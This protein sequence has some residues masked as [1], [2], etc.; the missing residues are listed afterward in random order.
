LDSDLVHDN[1]YYSDDNQ[2][3]MER[4]AKINKSKQVPK[5]AQVSTF[6]EAPMKAGLLT[7]R[8]LKE[9]DA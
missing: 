8:G 1:G 3:V 5:G 6:D 7:A 2:A 9:V 4:T